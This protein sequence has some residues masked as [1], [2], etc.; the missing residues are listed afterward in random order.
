MTLTVA[1]SAWQIR[2]ARGDGDFF[3]H[4]YDHVQAAY[5]AGA[6][7]LVLPELFVLELLSLAPDVEERHMPEFLAQWS[8]AIEDWLLRISASSGI[9]LVGGS[10]FRKAGH[11]RFQN[12]T[13]TATPQGVLKTYAKNKL[14]S[15]EREIWELQPGE[16][17]ATLTEEVIGSLI[18]YDSEF[19]EACRL[20]VQSGM[21]L[22]C[23]PTF[24]EDRYGYE[25]VRVS[26]LAR[27]LEN[28]IF[29]AQ[30]S[31]LGTLDREPVPSTYGSSAILVPSCREFP[32]GSVLAETSLGEEGLAV[33]KLDFA[34][35]AQIRSGGEV[36]NWA[37]R[38][39]SS[40]S[41]EPKQVPKR[42]Q[43]AS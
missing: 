15:Y 20:L 8:S 39:A 3:G 14:T 27:A 7:V 16:G 36:R 43:D 10:Y 4:M 34:L 25:R 37:D 30:S 32:D 11:K 19:P 24:T 28:Q 42:A 21:Q 33:A 40:W 12:V 41:A 26:C 9:T 22:L 18:C 35:L 1:A 17:L 5:D 13:A 2:H 23:V 29:V 6:K 38:D 31:L